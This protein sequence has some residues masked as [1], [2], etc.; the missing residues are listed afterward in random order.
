VVQA[1]QG[2]DTEFTPLT[3]SREILAAAAEHLVVPETSKPGDPRSTGPGQSEWS[4][5]PS[6]KRRTTSRT[7]R[8]RVYSDGPTLSEAPN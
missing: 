7:A 2:E 8:L 6:P 5:G 1:D 4:R 3:H